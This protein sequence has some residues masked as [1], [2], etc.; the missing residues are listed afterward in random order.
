MKKLI[1]KWLE[2]EEPKKVLDSEEFR[3]HL[4]S[5]TKVMVCRAF[6]ELFD[7]REFEEINS[8]SGAWEII[9]YK[10]LL[11]GF[12][13]EAITSIYSDKINANISGEEFI[14]SIVKRIKDK[15]L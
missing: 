14:D 2:L 11:E 13:N 9:K 6:K 7:Q 15:Q 12:I 3:G 8:E 5:L 10:P 4:E 1:R